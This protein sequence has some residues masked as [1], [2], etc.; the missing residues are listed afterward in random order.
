MSGFAGCSF[1]GAPCQYRDQ[2]RT[3]FG[4]AVQIA[5]QPFRRHRQSGE[6]LVR[7]ALLLGF[8]ERG[9]AEHA[10]GAG[11]GD[12][13]AYVRRTLGDEHPDQRIA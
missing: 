11:A 12:G 8:F 3:I 10:F 1:N 9:D 5:V 13:D 7:E 2:M 4:A 6:H